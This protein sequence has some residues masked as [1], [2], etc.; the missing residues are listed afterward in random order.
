MKARVAYRGKA[1]VVASAACKKGKHSRC[2]MQ[3]CT[4][5]CGHGLDK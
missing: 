2:L 4:C 5:A 1:R 3:D